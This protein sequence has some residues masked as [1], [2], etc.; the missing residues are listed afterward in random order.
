[1]RLA[2]GWVVFGMTQLLPGYCV[3]LAA[4]EV[5]EL[6]DLDAAARAQFL[7]DMT[8]V[9]DAIRAE[10]QPDRLNYEILGN[11]LPILHAHI[12]PRYEDELDE[13]RGGPSWFYGSE[14][15]RQP[16]YSWRQPEHRAMM[17]RLRSRLQELA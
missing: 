13:F 1:M 9:G 4:P 12:R 7:S 11:A 5:R 2:S 14:A 10:C 17:E 16:E 3:L 15:F 8:L 6:N